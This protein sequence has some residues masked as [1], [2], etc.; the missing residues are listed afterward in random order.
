MSSIDCIYEQLDIDPSEADFGLFIKQRAAQLL[1]IIKFKLPLIFIKNSTPY[2]ALF[3]AFGEYEVPAPPSL[4]T[5]TDMEKNEFLLEMKAVSTGIGM[6]EL[7]NVGIEDIASRFGYSDLM[8][9]WARILIFNTKYH[10]PK[11]D[12]LVTVAVYLYARASFDDDPDQNMKQEIF[13]YYSVN[14]TDVEAV[15]RS[16]A[17]LEI[18]IW[19]DNWRTKYRPIPTEEKIGDEQLCTKGNKRVKQSSRTPPTSK[20]RARNLTGK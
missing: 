4:I 17:S 19:F 20:K 9:D 18:N 3:I 7:Y 10:W 11:V 8:L 12:I 13:D 16:L 6:L 2:I 1:R 15:R 5:S 14:E